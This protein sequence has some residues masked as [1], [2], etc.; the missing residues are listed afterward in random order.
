MKTDNMIRLALQR[1]NVAFG[2]WAQMNA[3]EFCEIAA[4][5]GMDFVIV[6]MEHGALGI[7][8]AVPMIRAIEAGGAAPVVRVPDTSRSGILKALDAGAVGIIIPNVDNREMAEQVVAAAT[9]G[10]RGKRGA[11]PCVRATNHGVETW[12]EYLDWCERNIMVAVTIETPDG[13]KNYEEIISVPGIAF[14]NMGPFDLS[15]AMGLKGDWKHP[16]VLAKEEEM[17]RLARARGIEIMA[18]SF[19]S[20]VVSL[21]EQV[22]GWRALGV[23]MFAVSG[24]RFMLSSS[25]RAVMA[26]LTGNG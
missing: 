16:D 21:R 20:D 10:P 2:T 11:C 23:R 25:Y 5:S 13:I 6:D 17:V 18:N 19:D 12:H 24:D 3:P 26:S 7:D 9:Y 14:I 15:Q 1:N 4:H 22:D 8:G